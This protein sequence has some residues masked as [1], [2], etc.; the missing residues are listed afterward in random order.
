MDTQARRKE[1]GEISRRSK[2]CWE[3]QVGRQNQAN[4]HPEPPGTRQATNK[5]TRCTS[6]HWFR[7]LLQPSLPRDLSPPFTWEIHEAGET[8]H[9][10]NVEGEIPRPR[11]ERDTAPPYF[12]DSGILYRCCHALRPERMRQAINTKQTKQAR[13]PSTKQD[14]YRMDKEENKKEEI[15]GG[16]K[17]NSR[18]KGKERKTTFEAAAAVG[19]TSS[20]QI[21]MFRLL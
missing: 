8:L 10:R 5:R 18:E 3:W 4:Q 14:F 15:N 17:C 13:H 2:T 20:T 1:K 11:R 6:R 7:M 16:S 12:V 21:D 9:D 19:G